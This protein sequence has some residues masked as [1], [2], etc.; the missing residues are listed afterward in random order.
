MP[1]T[2]VARLFLCL[3][4]LFTLAATARALASVPSFNI[5]QLAL[6]LPSLSTF[7]KCIAAANLTDALS[8]AGPFTVFAPSDAAF[9]KVDPQQLQ[10]LLQHR[11]ALLRVLL[12]HVVPGDYTSNQLH[13]HQVLVTKLGTNGTLTIGIA[14]A[15]VYVEVTHSNATDFA[16]VVTADQMATN[17]VI[18]TADTLL[19]P[20]P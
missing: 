19:I 6:S 20:K 18:H 11:D 3:L 14:S 13:D 5:V 16:R 4:P 17:G 10:Y 1:S 2:L 12:L 7:A 15:V 9:A 8:A